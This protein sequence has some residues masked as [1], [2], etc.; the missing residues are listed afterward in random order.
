MTKDRLLD[1][2]MD[3]VPFRPNTQ[4]AIK[5][6]LDIMIPLGKSVTTEISKLSSECDKEYIKKS[7]SAHSKNAAWDKDF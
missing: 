2:N 7:V 6:D 4:D 1:K 5:K 3:S